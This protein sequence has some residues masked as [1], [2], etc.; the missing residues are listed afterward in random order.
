MED[1]D[2]ID[3]SIQILGKGGKVRVVLVGRMTKKALRL[4]IR[5]RP[6]GVGPLFTKKDGSRLTYGGL[7]S[8]LLRR[9]HQA[10]AT[11]VTLHDFRRAFTLNQLQAGVPETTIMRLLGHSSTQL[12]AI[13]SRQT[14]RH[15]MEVFHSVVNS[16]L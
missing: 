3:G 6:R 13:Y 10:R 5:K 8:L 4:W 9:S 16:E 11:G 2:L 15:L 1:L 12:I 14:T 7:R